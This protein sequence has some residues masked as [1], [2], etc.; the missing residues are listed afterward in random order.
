MAQ[1]SEDRVPAQPATRGE[2]CAARPG[3]GLLGSVGGGQG[4]ILEVGR[5]SVDHS[6]LLTQA[7]EGFDCAEPPSQF[8]GDLGISEDDRAGIGGFACLDSRRNSLTS[9]WICRSC[10]SVNASSDVPGALAHSST[11][12]FRSLQFL[13]FAP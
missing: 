8:L 11:G 3:V 13:Q 9:L 6:S 12:Q 5:I 4:R 2:H 1:D 10:C 7:E